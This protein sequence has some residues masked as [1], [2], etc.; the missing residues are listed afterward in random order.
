MLI[1]QSI[2]LVQLWSENWFVEEIFDF[3]F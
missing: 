1:N 2:T 3:D